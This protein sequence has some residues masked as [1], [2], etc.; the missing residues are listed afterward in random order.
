MND[1]QFTNLSNNAQPKMSAI[2]PNYNSS[3]FLPLS[4]QSLL[5][6]T[7]PFDEIIIVDDGSTDNSLALIESFMATNPSIK[8]IRHQTNQGVN[9]AVNTGLAAVSGDFILFCAADDWFSSN[10]VAAAKRV[11]IQHPSVGLICGDAIV[12]RFDLKEPFHRTLPFPSNVYIS[13]DKFKQ[14]ARSGYVG[15]NGAGG[16]FLRKQAVLDAGSFYSATRWHGDWLLYFAVALKE[17]IFYVNEVFIHIDM[18]KLSYSEGK[19]DKKTQNKVMLDTLHIIKKHYPHLW[20]DFKEGALI[21]HHELRYIP[22]FLADPIARSFMSMR[23]IWKILINNS[24]IVRIGRLFPYHI[25]L[26]TRR[27]LR[28]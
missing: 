11:A 12:K 18:R 9:A 16:M 27:L 8:L 3:E 19:R 25:I 20:N 15:F 5:N 14:I 7:V 23:L 1:L 6:Q 10:M 13:A 4:I 2:L 22:L 24:L 21:P 28:A 17:G 26:K